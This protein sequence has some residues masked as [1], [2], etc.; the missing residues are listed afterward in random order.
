[1]SLA[2]LAK[3]CPRIRILAGEF[4]PCI[5][6]Q[7]KDAVAHFPLN[8]F[9]PFVWSM[10]RSEYQKQYRQEYK[11]HTKRVN[12]TFSRDEHRSL[13]RSAKSAGKQL[14]A[15]VKDLA[16]STHHHKAEASLPE[17]VLERLADLDRVFRTIA[18]NVNQIAWHSHTIRQVL[19]EQDVLAHL[20]RL[21]LELK[22]TLAE[23]GKHKPQK[24]AAS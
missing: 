24:A 8:P 22:D 2:L 15:Y 1:M 13:S 19:D 16:I 3:N 20:H 11:V 23:I 12:L 10:D 9:S 21:E 6:R 4:P 17:D 14:S 18:N 7:G 5:P